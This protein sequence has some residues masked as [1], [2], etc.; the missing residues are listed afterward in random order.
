M[1][2]LEQVSGLTKAA[3][4]KIGLNMGSVEE[5]EGFIIIRIQHGNKQTI[6]AVTIPPHWR[7]YE[8]ESLI[9]ALEKAVLEA[10]RIA[11]KEPAARKVDVQ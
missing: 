1:L 8:P 5:D 2:S 11:M 6:G 4:E 3:I 9:G 7:A 10:C